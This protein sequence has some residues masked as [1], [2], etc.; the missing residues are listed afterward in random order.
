MIRFLFYVRGWE[1]FFAQQKR[2]EVT[3]LQLDVA[4]LYGGVILPVAAGNLVLIGF[5][6]LE[7]GDFFGAALG[8]DLAGDRS[9]GGIVSVENLL[10]VGMDGQNGPEG[11]LFAHVPANPLNPNGVAG[12]DAILLPPGLNDSVHR[13]SE[14]T[15]KQRLYGR[16]AQ[17]VNAVEKRHNVKNEGFG[18]ACW[19]MQLLCR[20]GVKMSAG[21]GYGGKLSQPLR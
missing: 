14:P 13:S 11:H 12:R 10:F 5:L 2:T 7:N 17:S 8:H 3:P 20:I 6:E 9:L 19:P 21:I 18:R 16:I 4:D 1:R 15:G